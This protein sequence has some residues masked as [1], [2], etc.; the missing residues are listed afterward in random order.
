MLVALIAL[1]VALGGG[2]YA[3]LKLPKNSVGPAQLKKGA[4]TPPKL[5]A[6]ARSALVTPGPA[7][8]TGPRGPDGPKG[9]AGPHGDA[10]PKGDTGPQGPGATTLIWDEGA[11]ASP[12]LKTIGTVLG[13]TFSGEC[14]IPAA[15][16]AE[17]KVY[18]QTSDGSLRWDVGTEE[19]DN[20]VEKGRSAST[21]QPVGTIVAPT[22]VA[23][24]T[25]EPGEKIDHNSQVVQMKPTPGYL[26]VHTTAST[27]PTQGCHVSILSFPSG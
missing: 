26:S 17:V 7:G 12:S 15:G 16:K 23:G 19:T 22:L 4:V 8:A 27:S 13:D 10:G 2:A 6:E 25:A 20:G 5:S 11:S 21:N 1:F 14:S 3:A 24:G 18:I 9:D